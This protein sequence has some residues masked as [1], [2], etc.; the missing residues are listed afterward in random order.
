MKLLRYHLLLIIAFVGSLVTLAQEAVTVTV[1]PV[2]YVL[3]PHL[4]GYLDN[5]GRYFTLS[6][7]NN[8]D[9]TQN[10]FMGMQLNQVTPTTDLRVITPP[11]RQPNQPFSIA[12]GETKVL[13]M[14]E[15]KTMFNHLAMSDISVTGEA[16]DGLLPEGT[17]E[18]CLMAYKWDPTLTSP[19]PLSNPLNGHCTFRICYLAEA[20]SFTYPVVGIPSALSGD[21][22]DDVQS[23]SMSYVSS[24]MPRFIWTVPYNNCG[25]AP[26]NIDYTFTVKEVMPG[27]SPMEAM[28]YGAVI[29]EKPGLA[30]AQCDI[31]AAY[32]KRM[33]SEA[34]YV[35]QVV[36]KANNTQGSLNFMA[37]T[38][39]GKSEIKLFRITDLSPDELP[40]ADEQ[41]TDGK[42]EDYM[43]LW[44][45]SSAKDSLRA[46]SLYKFRNPTIT[47]PTFY[48]GAA[49]KIFINDDLK[50]EWRDVWHVGGEGL[51]PE[52]LKFEYEV[53]LFNGKNNADME[54]ALQGTPFYKQRVT[55]NSD[56]IKWEKLKDHVEKGDYLVL[57][58]VPYCL[59]EESIEYTGDDLNVK[60]FAITE[61]IY[62]S[63]LNC[64]DQTDISN[65][66]PTTLKADELKGKTVAI[67]EYELTLGDDIKGTPEEGFSGTGHVEW[68]PLDT[69]FMVAVKFENLKINNQNVVVAGNAKS[70]PAEEMS[71]DDVIETLFSEWGVDNL[72]TDTSIPY[73]DQLQGLTSENARSLAKELNIA[74]YY[75]YY[76]FGKG[77]LN[78]LRGASV[79]DLHLP[80]CI[81]DLYN[82]SPVDIQIADMT[83][84][85]TYATMNLIGE[86]VTNSDV[87]EN[88]VLIFGAPF[89][90][91][92]PDR[93]LPETGNLC[94]LADFK[95]KD[96]DSGY[97]CNFIAPKDLKQ[98]TE[99]CYVS[100]INDEFGRLQ[101]H[102]DM[103]IPDL[104]KEVNGKATDELPILT[105]RTEID[106][107]DHWIGSATMD[108][109]QS[110]DLP[111]Y[112]FQP[113]HVLIDHDNKAN[114]L[115]FSLPKDYSFT[116]A[117]ITDIEEFQGLYMKDLYV[118]IPDFI[119]SESAGGEVTDAETGEKTEVKVEE[120]RIKFV[121]NH[122]Y[123]DQNKDFT[124]KASLNTADV[125]KAETNE[126]GG[127]AISLDEIYVNVLQS[128]L[129]HTGFRG[130]F[131]V[132]LL[133]DKEGERASINY[134]GYVDG[135]DKAEGKTWIFKTSQ[136]VDLSLDFFL[137]EATFEKEQTYFL[138]EKPENEDTRVEL[139]LGGKISLSSSLT[140]NID[141]AAATALNFFIP[142]IKFDRMRLANCERWKSGIDKSQAAQYE[143]WLKEWGGEKDKDTRTMVSDDQKVHFDIG[144]WSFASPKKKMGGLDF[145]ITEF[146]LNTDNIDDKQVGL[147]IGGDLLLLDGKIAFGTT[148]SVMAEVDW[149]KKD[150]KY[151]TTK[152]HEAHIKA[153]FAKIG[154]ITLEGK[155]VVDDNSNH[156]GYRGE[157]KFAMP[158]DLFKFEAAGAYIEAK[159]SADVIKKEQERKW[160]KIKDNTA[161]R[162]LDDGTVINSASQVEIDDSYTY[163]FLEIS[164]NSSALSAIQP[165][166]IT[167]LRG[168]FYMNCRKKDFDTDFSADNVVESYG[169]VG[170]MIGLDMSCCGENAITAGGQLTVLY[171]TF[172]DRLSTI[173]IRADVHAILGENKKKGLINAGATIT[174]LS[175]EEQKYLD[176]DVTFDSQAD[177]DEQLAEFMG[178]EAFAKLKDVSEK[179]IGLDEL[180]AKSEDDHEKNK[181]TDSDSKKNADKE[182]SAHLSAGVKINMNFRITWRDNSVDYKSAKWHI[183]VGKPQEDERCRM[184]YIDFALGKRS[185]KFAMWATVYADAY[186]CF[187]NEL[188]MDHL[189]EIPDEISEYLGLK[190]KNIDSQGDLNAQANQNR[191]KTFS[192]F[193]GKGNNG[194]VMFGAKFYG[195]I[196]L[197]AGLIYFRSTAIVGGDIM[198]QKLKKG[199]RCIGGGEAGKNGW[200]G[201]GQL[202]AML[203]GEL[204]LD[205]DLWIYRGKISLID[206]GL[207]SLLKA[208]MPNPTW[209]FGKAKAHYRLLGGLIKGSASVQ[210]KAGQ[211]CT[212]EFANPLDDIKIFGDVTPGYEGQS[213]GWNKENAVSCNTY[214][215]FNTNMEM[216]AVLPLLDESRAYEMADFDEELTKYADKA[217]RF[218]RFVLLPDTIRLACYDANQAEASKPNP[219]FDETITYST[220]DHEL[221]NVNS[222]TLE[223][224]KLYRLTL[225]GQAQEYYDGKW[226]DPLFNDES[227]GHKNKAKHW[228][229]TENYYFRTSDVPPS[230]KE[231]IAIFHTDY[232]Q[233]ILRP[234][235]ALRRS[236][237]NV[238]KF[239][240]PDAPITLRL[241][242]RNTRK[243]IGWETPDKV[244][245]NLQSDHGFYDDY[246]KWQ[247]LYQQCYDDQYAAWQEANKDALTGFTVEETTREDY[248]DYKGYS[249]MFDVE[250]FKPFHSEELEAKLKEPM[251]TE[252]LE[253]GGLTELKEVVATPDRTMMSTQVI[254]TAETNTTTIRATGTIAN[255]SVLNTTNLNTST[256]NTSAIRGSTA[257]TSA[258]RSATVSGPAPDLFVL[259]TPDTVLTRTSATRATTTATAT[260]A[261]TTATAAAD[262]EGTT[263]TTRPTSSSATSLRLT[264]G[265]ATVT[266]VSSSSASTSADDGTV[267]EYKEASGKLLEQAAKFAKLQEQEAEAE[268]E[269]QSQ[270]A[271][272]FTGRLPGAVKVA[273]S[274]DSNEAKILEG[275]V[276]E[277]ATSGSSGSSQYIGTLSR[278]K[279]VIYDAASGKYLCIWG[280][281]DKYL[282]APKFTFDNSACPGLGQEPNRDAYATRDYETPCYSIELEEVK[283]NNDFIFLRT[284]AP[285]SDDIFKAVTYGYNQ[286]R[287]SLNRIYKKRYDE[288]LKNIDQLVEANRTRKAELT[289]ATMG[290]AEMS[291]TTSFEVGDG[292]EAKDAIS[293]YIDEL[294][295]QAVEDSM[296]VQQLKMKT[297]LNDFSECLYERTGWIPGPE[298]NS[299]LES[300]KND[301]DGT[302]G[303]NIYTHLAGITYKKQPPTTDKQVVSDK[304]YRTDPYLYMAYVGNWA[305]LGGIELQGYTGLP[306]RGLTVKFG[307]SAYRLGNQPTM[308]GLLLSSNGGSTF[309]AVR[310]QMMFGNSG[311]AN[312]KYTAAHPRY[313]EFSNYMLRNVNIDCR[314]AAALHDAIYAV[315]HIYDPTKPK[316]VYSKLWKTY[317]GIYAN[318]SIGYKKL[319]NGG[320]NSPLNSFSFPYR[321]VFLMIFADYQNNPDYKDHASVYS[322][323]ANTGKLVNPSQDLLARSNNLAW[324]LQKD[325]SRAVTTE[326]IIAD[327][328]GSN[329]NLSL[330]NGPATFGSNIQKLNF[331][332]YRQNSF[333]TARNQG[334]ADSSF[335]ICT[336]KDSKNNYYVP[337]DI[338]PT[339]VNYNYVPEYD[340]ESNDGQ[341]NSL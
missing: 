198:I 297:T 191:V 203:K 138:V 167:G 107:W 54:Q 140:S 125:L 119:E 306:L 227:T 225:S 52:S 79:D 171:D 37:F 299:F 196:G 211:V 35:A 318:Y 220:K 26:A 173:R 108:A 321:Q 29:Y 288:F 215:Q 312:H 66:T 161:A 130:K 93:L 83:F 21:F 44:G 155:L 315:A 235:F 25:L 95:V 194:G 291:G 78:T 266:R 137:A 16:K 323:Y 152:F 46:D 267:V 121:L 76:K 339:S 341:G 259:W 238:D 2:Q 110:E 39:S 99:G 208:G 143:A 233:D 81:D 256:L 87:V 40:T 242:V 22:G 304:A 309:S 221:F 58:V 41:G 252:A 103:E 212:P 47:S 247:A 11:A 289:D 192:E 57:R 53:Q 109:F 239:D 224:G 70:Y 258:L 188:P 89:L 96:P 255:T 223:I 272:Y 84:T 324:R 296:S 200:Y 338:Y 310:S 158:G 307:A 172:N 316:D 279:T 276:Y 175:N 334:G 277:G 85:P 231:D 176:V 153:D 100:W 124:C 313:N 61:H 290:D 275:V 151:K 13:N 250:T 237:W 116:T 38:N 14:V 246:Q 71:E 230:F 337:Q 301:P 245:D 51:K 55:T 9:Q 75:T 340:I 115:N 330:N 49:R 6:L 118:A 32:L 261:T 187:G 31:P 178:S 68:N 241:E 222:G 105:V 320:H 92:S 326:G 244:M 88:E 226:Q 314:T 273:D 205:I 327:S 186:L 7:Q 127:W 65:T 134:D 271:S 292:A 197:N 179:N 336:S 144:K 287:I 298:R 332:I 43:V 69:K 154:G 104:K 157:L 189:P 12:P 123:F 185:D 136:D 117:G 181:N 97:T 56:E 218:Y 206:V 184:T 240:D 145:N 302:Y 174:Y 67:G 325:V 141:G 101:L 150:L 166:S 148:V 228:Y 72:L 131:S 322:S 165:V 264:S 36:A 193:Q 303:P 257:T 142:G 1:M 253:L 284:K 156:K 202:Y 3:P 262:T 335:D 5:P 4:G 219:T 98:P 283:V 331:E 77:S 45:R 91:M 19:Y 329:G 278:Q 265:T 182:S 263:T 180:D 248:M 128:Q 236:R 146:S 106:D 270:Q 63:L 319:S 280:D 308:D 199:T 328:W 120:K 139:C 333:H 160:D 113:G 195:D 114:E 268:E 94:L 28:D 162:T 59:N 170:G 204:G 201:T 10:V 229:Q 17:Y 293:Q 74:D 102:V 64:A 249:S 50:V 311:D 234:V 24:Q 18:A 294:V 126:L 317:D 243:K 159:K 135:A 216:G 147:D 177:M 62:P 122:L 73:A 27:Q 129:G 183:Y 90:C 169:M 209:V 214:P 20:P 274:D 251:L 210:L 132:P 281:Y 164:V 86:F 213:E 269:Q 23:L 42:D 8:T 163:A 80:V 30:I 300:V 295:D 82:D 190:Q 111:G 149:S 33:N 207:G 260:R 282:N 112:S 286:Y 232:R 133:K 15:M 34:T 48:E 217:S 305:M 285:I 60:D 168:G 254:K